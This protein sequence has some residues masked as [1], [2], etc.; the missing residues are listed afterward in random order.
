MWAP[1]ASFIA[2]NQVE[3]DCLEFGVFEG[4]SFAEAF[5][6]V[7]RQRR[8]VA[9]EVARSPALAQWLAA[10]PRFFAFDSFA[11]VPDGEADRQADTVPV[12]T[13]ARR[14]SSVPIS[15]PKASI[16]RALSPYPACMTRAWC[17]RSKS[18]TSCA[19]PR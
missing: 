7:E 8:I 4:A 15:R 14:A 1:A 6:S 3:G 12:P 10:K 19:V 5:R 13:P 17:R 11:G 18:G 2:W 9:R 16:W